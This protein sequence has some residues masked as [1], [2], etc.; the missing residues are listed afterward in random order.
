MNFCQLFTLSTFKGNDH[1]VGGRKID[2]E[3]MEFFWRTTQRVDV[4]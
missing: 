3:P 1:L 2:R 4:Y